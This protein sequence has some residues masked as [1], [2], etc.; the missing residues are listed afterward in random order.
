MVFGAF[1][2]MGTMDLQIVQRRQNTTEYIGSSLNGLVCVK[3]TGFFNR[4]MLQSTPLVGQKIFSR[5]IT[6]FF[7]I[8]HVF[9]GL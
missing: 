6:F 7:W 1:S 3:K 9:I 5:L 8:I 4:I 2:Y